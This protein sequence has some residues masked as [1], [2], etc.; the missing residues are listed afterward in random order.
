[1]SQRAAAVTERDQA[2]EELRQTRDE[3]AELRR[4]HAS[5][6]DRSREQRDQAW[7]QTELQWQQQLEAVQD[8]RSQLLARAE[9]AEQQVDALTQQL[10]EPSTPR[11]PEPN[12]TEGA[13]E[14]DS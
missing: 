7:R 3:I 2:R 4:S 13:G 10:R 8:A 1:M 5:E 6:L 12:P 14:P 11:D 9:R